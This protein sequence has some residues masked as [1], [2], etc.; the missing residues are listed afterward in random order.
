MKRSPTLLL[1]LSAGL[2]LL[3]GERGPGEPD[4]RPDA[5]L[6][7]PGRRLG[8]RPARRRRRIRAGR[9]A[10]APPAGPR[11][12]ASNMKL[13]TTS[14][15]LSKLGP[16]HRIP[17][18]VFRDG[19]VDAD[20][21]LHGSLYLQGGGDPALGTPSFYGSYLAGLGT[22]LFSLTPADQGRRDRVDHRPPLRR[23]HDLR[24]PPR[25][26]RLRLRDQLLHRPPLRARLQLRLQRLDQRQRLLLRP[27]QAGGDEAGRL[28]ARGRGRR[29]PRRS[30]C[31]RRPPNAERVG[32]DP[33]PQPRPH[34]QHHRRLLRQLLRRDADQAARR[35]IRRRRHHRRGRR[36]G[37]GLRPRQRLRRAGRSTAPA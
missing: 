22:N 30:P 27:G 29:S 35:R 26:R 11:P 28:A 12:L 34:R 8:Q 33:L 20:G 3:L 32:A 14:T 10:P 24:P 7:A 21:V 19:K 17:T 16:E 5:R 36:R 4:L 9:S 23:R 37:R 1:V 15:A 6:A 18:K 31:G 2:F 25:R 13:F